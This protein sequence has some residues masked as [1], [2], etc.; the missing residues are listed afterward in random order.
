VEPV[1]VAHKL[2]VM[3]VKTVVAQ[4]LADEVTTVAATNNNAAVAT[5]LRY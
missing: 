1:L 5:R 2:A 4:N 3:V